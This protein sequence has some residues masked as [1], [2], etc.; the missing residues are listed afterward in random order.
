MTGDNPITSSSSQLNNMT[1][2]YIITDSSVQ[3]TRHSFQGR[4]HI[5]II[6]FHIELNGK[7][8]ES[9]PAF[10]VQQIPQSIKNSNTIKLIP[11]SV[12]ELVD[13][14]TD[15][16]RVATDI[17]VIT[18][19]S[20][21][22]PVWENLEQAAHAIRGKVRLQLIDSQTI[23][24][25]LGYLVQI[26]ADMAA[27]G[28]PPAEIEYQVRGRIPHIYSQFCLPNM[29]YLNRSGIMG[30]PQAVVGEMLTLM[31]IFSFEEGRLISVE[32]VRNPRHLLDNFQ[33][34]MDEFSELDYVAFMQSIPAMITEARALKEHS[35]LLFPKTPF[36]EHTINPVLAAM[37]GPHSVGIFAIENPE[38]D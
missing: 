16:S 29:T 28:K 30:Y 6:P 14:L 12:N 21:L 5:Q 17:I 18:L 36:S 7:L 8:I 35:S 3:F 15:L 24:L 31:P 37:F 32:K 26:A 22:S 2:T 4:N 27:T 10:K 23:G 9:D 33:E 34:F 13:V 1:A 20:H 11:P 19:S 38:I 25:G